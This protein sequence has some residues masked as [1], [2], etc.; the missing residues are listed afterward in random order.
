[1]NTS[2]RRVQEAARFI[3]AVW[4][5]HRT[6][7]IA[8]EA[9]Q[10]LEDNRMLRS[11]ETHHQVSESAE[12]YPGELTHLRSLYRQ[13]NLLLAYGTLDAIESALSVHHTQETSMRKAAGQTE[14]HRREEP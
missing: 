7:D 9:A 10:V 3:Q 13:L 14:P 11:P 5:H 2:A 12:D 4:K 1:M 8:A 6:P